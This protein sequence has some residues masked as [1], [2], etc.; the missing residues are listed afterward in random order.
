MSA[1]PPRYLGGS[2]RSVGAA[3]ADA[4][5]GCAVA[6]KL[7]VAVVVDETA[8]DDPATFQFETK[9]LREV[10]ADTGTGANLARCRLG[11]L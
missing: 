3:Q 8:V 9:L 7:E 11:V 2:A 10:V 5:V 1:R 4:N 6:V